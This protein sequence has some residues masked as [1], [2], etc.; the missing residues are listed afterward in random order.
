MVLGQGNIV[1][2]TSPLWLPF[3][4][5]PVML[6]FDVSFVVRMKMLLNKQLSCSWYEMCWPCDVTI[7]GNCY[8]VRWFCQKS[9]WMCSLEL[10]WGDVLNHWAPIHYQQV[11]ENLV[12]IPLCWLM[13]I[14]N[15]TGP[16]NFMLSP[17]MEVSWPEAML[18]NNHQSYFTIWSF[19]SLLISLEICFKA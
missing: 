3:T 19:K 15:I 12:W 4:K 10:A 5:G 8:D 11:W 13:A 16:K 2:I 9:R 18:L 17:H 14:Y 6:N 1:C 7:M